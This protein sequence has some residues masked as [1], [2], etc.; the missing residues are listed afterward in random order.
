M[1]SGRAA[2]CAQRFGLDPGQK[3]LVLCPGA[4]FGGAKRWPSE[5]YAAVAD[6]YLGRGWQVALF[7]SSRDSEVTGAIVADASGRGIYDLAGRT[8]LA[9][10]I[11]L[12]QT[13]SDGQ[14][15][16]LCVY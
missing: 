12:M 3:L 1:D 6:E 5:Y 2:A 11:D 8:S 4:E 16:P 14:D 10:A 13:V 15:T 7:G 9:D